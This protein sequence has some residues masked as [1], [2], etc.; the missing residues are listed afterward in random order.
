[1]AQR[2]PKVAIIGAGMSGICM[3]AKLQDADID[4]FTIFEK[5]H[6]VGGTWRDNTY[7]G[8]HCD[9]P[10]RFYS[11]SFR[12]NPKWSHLLSPGPE[13]H[14]YFQQVA[15]E[16]GIRPH[17]R[18]GRDVTRARYDGGKWHLTTA[19]GDETFD[20]VVTATGFLR[21]PRYPEIPGRDTFAGPAFHSARWDH[22]VSLADKRIGLI[23]TGS[24]GVQITAELGGKVR[25]LKIFQRTAQWVYPMPNGRYSALTRAALTRRPSLNRMPYLFWGLLFRKFFGIAPVRPGWQRRVLQA[26]CR[27]NLRIS[28]RDPELRAKLTPKDQ[29]M[30][31]RQVMAG[32]FY[33]SVRQPGVE[34]ITEAIDHIEPS[35]IVTADGVLH[36]VDLLVFA[37]GFDARAYVRPME[38]I[39]EGGRTLD[40]VWADGPMA[41]RSVAVPGFPNLF[42]M[43]GPHSPIGNQSLVPIAED[44][45]NYVM[46]WIEQLRAGRVLAA[47]PTEA[48]TKQYNEDMKA[49]MPQ[50]IWVTGC[51]SWY[52]G[53]DGL[54]ELFPWTPETHHELLRHPELADFDVRTA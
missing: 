46:W 8:L 22:S 34:V 32:H 4:S 42:M 44:Q 23:G 38:I 27:W 53:K 18:F 10:S 14:A 43:V 2:A 48:A 6:D 16:R 24:T 26:M 47:A 25:G 28:V 21:V 37:T 45:A 39:G 19:D 35:G 33:R 11:Y 7:P 9:V 1:M 15:D 30:C 52:L 50:T 5:A 3:A 54:P 13:I 20:V 12:P 49:A 36:E 51:S 40:E 31:K 29:P 17:I 41:Y